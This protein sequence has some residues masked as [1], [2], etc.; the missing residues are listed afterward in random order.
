[1]CIYREVSRDGS[2]T[3]DAPFPRR[4]QREE[5]KCINKMLFSSLW[6]LRRKILDAV[7]II[8]FTKFLQLVTR[9]NKGLRPISFLFF[10]L[11]RSFGREQFSF[12]S[13]FVVDKAFNNNFN[14][15]NSLDARKKRDRNFSRST[16]ERIQF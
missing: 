4:V 9:E 13:F 3:R 8:K 16:L 12:V 2:L 1:M 15:F 10:L 14:K 11:Q 6:T 5:G 7:L